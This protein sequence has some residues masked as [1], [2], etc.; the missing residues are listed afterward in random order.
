MIRP[1]AH[2]VDRT[3]WRLHYLPG[4][5]D[6]LSRHQEGN[7]RVC[8]A[9]KLTLT[10]DQKVLVAAIGIAGRIGVVLEQID[11]TGD[12]FFAEALLR[13]H[14]KSLKDSLSCFV[15]NNGRDDVVTL[16]SGV[17]RVTANIKVETCTVAEEDVRTTPP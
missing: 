12:A 4:T 10:T 9:T 2:A 17:F 13:V 15:V 8:Q 6:D 7:E 3:A 16:G 5:T 11:I 1:L 14:E